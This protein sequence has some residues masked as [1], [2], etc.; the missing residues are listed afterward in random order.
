MIRKIPALSRFCELAVLASAC[1][2]A[3]PVRAGAV[4]AAGAGQV[5]LQKM[6]MASGDPATINDHL[7]K[8]IGS[9]YQSPDNF[10]EAGKAWMKENGITDFYDTFSWGTNKAWVDF[11][12]YRV[13]NSEDE[14]TGVGI[15]SWHTGFKHLRFRE[16]GARGGLVEGMLEIKDE[17]TIVRHYEFFRPDGT[18]SYHS[19][20]W[21]F[22]PQ[23]TQC[24]S[25]LSTDYKDG[26]AKERAAR[27]FCKKK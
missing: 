24:F 9:W 4:D 26:V 14:K 8:L 3:L 5:V 13:A 21:V 11:G 2:L 16:S 19:D 25:W 22:D 18:V 23:N 15:I 10:S 17:N 20:A 12:D 1:L 27:K 6:T 7:Q